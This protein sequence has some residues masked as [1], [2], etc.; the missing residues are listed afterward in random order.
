[1]VC[2]PPGS[3]KSTYCSWLFPAWYVGRNPS[4]SLIS[5]SHNDDL[6][7]LF[8]RKVRNMVR[9]PQHGALF[10]TKLAP[11]L[12]G[13]GEWETSEGGQ[14][15][16][17]G[18]LGSMAGHRAD[19]GTIDDP[20]P[21]RRQADSDTYRKRCWDAYINDFVPRLKP[22]AARLLVTTRW[23][24][25]DLAGRCLDKEAGLWHLLSI[26]MVAEP[27]DRLGRQPGER[28][29]PEWFT[30][31]MVDDA[32]R[33]TR[34]WN[35]LYQQQPAAMEG[36]YFKFDWFGEY[37]QPP[38]QLNIYGASDYAVSDGAG[39][40]TEHG[41]FGVDAWS[42][43]YVLDWWREQSA[44]DRWIESQ[45]DMILR[46]EPLIWFGEGGVIRKAVE[47]F[48]LKRMTERRAFC[49]LEWLAPIGDKPVRARP[50]QALASMGKVFFPAAPTSWKADLIGQLLRFPAGRF[51]DGVDVC[52]LL[53]RGLE[54]VK[55]PKLTKPA[56]NR[57][58][59]T[60]GGP[61]NNWMKG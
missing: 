54:Y 52:S 21:S 39:D 51:D 45:C 34:A 15:F 36:D 29:W 4:H 55:P 57:S 2:M 26:P 7:W 31:A 33:D 14:Y 20:I 13:A 30:E 22:H 37:D 61:S 18:I 35:A 59:E 41:I 38:G 23:H 46:H 40:Y 49:R 58:V 16:A 60:S 44:S 50:F 6:A 8:G 17:S 9:S 28:L 3:A 56:A 43:V 10:R 5:A 11:D 12:S 1:M 48:L 24:D 19:L 32:K 25:D 53:G 27:G 47:P 42:N